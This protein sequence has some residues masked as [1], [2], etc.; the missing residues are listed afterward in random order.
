MRHRQSPG[1]RRRTVEPAA[2]AGADSGPAPLPRPRDRPAGHPQQRPGRTPEGPAGRRRR[3]P[4]H[5]PGTD[6]RDRVRADRRRPGAAARAQRAAGLGPALRTGTVPGRRGPARLGT[7]GRR[8]PAGRTARRAD[9]RA[10]GRTGVLLPR[11]RRRQAHRPPRAGTGR[12]RGGHHVRRHLL[13]PP[14]RPDDRDRRRPARHRRRRARDRPPRPG[15]ARRSRRQAGTVTCLPTT[16]QLG[17]TL[18]SETRSKTT[19]AAAPGG[20]AA[21]GPRPGLA[22]LVL[23][24]A[25]LM[26]VLDATIV[27]VALPHIQRALGFSGSNLE[28]VVNAYALA[29]GGLLLLGGRTGDLLGRRTMFIAGLLLFSAAS[30][31]GGFADSEAFLL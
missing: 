8:G 26:V 2:G 31:A 29:F 9:L 25:Q 19:R 5:P 24:A 18:M 14:D 1:R 15:A 30:L 23:A 3:H 16:R 13:Q 4:A 21:G 22:L 11:L 12:R 17:E 7:A 20:V 28:W 10:P 27:N 6:R